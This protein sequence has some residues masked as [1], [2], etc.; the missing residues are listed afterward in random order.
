V[1]SG[2]KNEES[3]AKAEEFPHFFVRRMRSTR[4]RECGTSFK[5]LSADLD[6]RAALVKIKAF[7]LAS[8]TWEVARGR[9]KSG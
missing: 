8:S 3:P 5:M 1:I 2:A 7:P 4:C 6:R 9:S